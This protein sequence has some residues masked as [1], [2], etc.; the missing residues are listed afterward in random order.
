MSTNTTHFEILCL[1][2]KEMW[3]L[4]QFG[5]CLPSSRSSVQTAAWRYVRVQVAQCDMAT[6]GPRYRVVGRARAQAGRTW[7]RRG[8]R[9]TRGAAREISQVRR[10]QTRTYAFAFGHH[11]CGRG[12]LGRDRRIGS[13]STKQEKFN[14]EN[15]SKPTEQKVNSSKVNSS[16]CKFH[17]IWAE[18]KSVKQMTNSTNANSSICQFNIS[19]NITWV[20]VQVNQWSNTCDRFF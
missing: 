11:N 10:T 15:S 8:V 4:S 9:M 14:S 2:W 20:K 16:K 19:T 13:M 5:H 17:H 6:R 12:Q 3:Y 18:Q 1:H 7:S